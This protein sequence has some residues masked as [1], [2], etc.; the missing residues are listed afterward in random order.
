MHIVSISNIGLP[1]KRMDYIMRL[2]YKRSK[3]P[4]IEYE[5]EELQSVLSSNFFVFF[6]LFFWS[7]FISLFSLTVHQSVFT[8]FIVFGGFFLFGIALFILLHVLIADSEK[9]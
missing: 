6:D 2:L 8:F 5:L 7:L 3:L 9:R 4:N 1:E